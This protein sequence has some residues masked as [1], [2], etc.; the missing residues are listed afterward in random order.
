LRD[1]QGCC[2]PTSML[3]RS[4]FP[5]STASSTALSVFAMTTCGIAG[6][7]LATLS[8]STVLPLFFL[9]L[10]VVDEGA[11]GA[12]VFGARD[13]LGLTLRLDRLGIS[14]GKLG[15]EGADAILL[16]KLSVGIVRLSLG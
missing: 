8:S 14:G 3:S 4:G 16:E 11:F 12:V 2:T 10:P 15:V 5:S 9:P 7:E 1:L 13:F 6:L